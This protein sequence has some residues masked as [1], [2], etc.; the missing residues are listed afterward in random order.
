[1]KELYKKLAAVKNEIGAISKDSTNPFFKS[2]YFD[3]NGLLN[4]V[5]NGG[6]DIVVDTQD[7]EPFTP[8]EET[9]F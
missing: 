1:M 3:I 6:N 4:H 7:I 2:K 8:S 9:P 5:E